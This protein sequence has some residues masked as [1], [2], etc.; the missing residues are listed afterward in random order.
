[1]TKRQWYFIKQKLIGIGVIIF[2][3]ISVIILEGDITACVVSVPAGVAL[4]FTKQMVWMD[5]YYYEIEEKERR[6]HS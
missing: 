5:D 2:G 1:M 6:G 3:I 4:I